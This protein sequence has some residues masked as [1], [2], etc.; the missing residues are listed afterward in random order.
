MTIRELLDEWI[1]AREALDLSYTRGAESSGAATRLDRAE[2]DLK[3]AVLA[4]ADRLLRIEEAAR[5]VVRELPLLSDR[6]LDVEEIDVVLSVG[7]IRTLRAALAEP[8]VTP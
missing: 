8:E 1:A 2:R 5:V 7:Q 4:N 6:A 3:N